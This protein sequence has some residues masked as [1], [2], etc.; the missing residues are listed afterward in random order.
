MTL[1]CYICFH[2]FAA[3]TFCKEAHTVITNNTYIKANINSMIIKHLQR[4]FFGLMLLVLFGLGN[5]ARA[6]HLASGDL[7]LDYIGTGPNDLTYRITLVIYKACEIPNAT[8]GNTAIIDISSASCNQS[9]LNLTIPM[10]QGPDTMDQLC[11]DFAPVN[12]C[13]E[14]NSPWPAFERRIYSMTYTLP[15]ACTDWIVGWGLGARNAGIENLN[16]PDSYNMYVEA[17][18]NNVA[19]WDN[20][21]PRFII[22][23]IPYLCAGQPSFFL[24]GPLDPDYVSMVRMN[25]DPWDDHNSPIPFKDPYN[26]PNPFN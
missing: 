8:L 25:V 19:K 23:P 1:I 10:T 11:P 2:H 14:I 15:M 22:D 7:Y 17:G 5:S 20:S 26:L 12:S 6:S 18:I 13:R 24:N 4:V 16:N 3:F 21:S 9:F